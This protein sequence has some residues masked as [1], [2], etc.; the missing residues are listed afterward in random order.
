MDPMRSLVNLP[1]IVYYFL[2]PESLW[3]VFTATKDKTKIKE[4]MEGNHF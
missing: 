3:A 1:R 2:N 4:N